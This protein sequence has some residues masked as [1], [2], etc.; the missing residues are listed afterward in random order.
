MD[1]KVYIE[2]VLREVCGVTE[3]TTCEEIIIKLAQAANLPGFYTLV[4]VYRGREDT[5]SADERLI[6][7]FR[8]IRENPTT[9]QFVLRRLEAPS[10]HPSRVSAQPKS[11]PSSAD[12]RSHVRQL[13][14]TAHFAPTNEAVGELRGPCSQTSAGLAGRSPQSLNNSVRLVGGR[15]DGSVETQQTSKDSSFNDHPPT[16]FESDEYEQLEDQLAYQEQ[17]VEFN[18]IRLLQLDKEIAELERA[19]RALAASD[20]FAMGPAAELAQLAATPWPQ[21]LE[22]NRTRQMDLVKE[23]ERYQIPLERIGVQLERAQEELTQLENKVAHELEHLLTTLD[24]ANAQR[25]QLLRSLS[26][27]PVRARL[28]VATKTDGIPV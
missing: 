25:R 7:F 22:A 2:G 15:S 9:V 19:N 12:H 4:A 1:L 5:L 23:R 21:L 17:E 28:P 3:S 13:S 27:T 24:S 10:P 6:E 14:S 20:A 18:R 8:K 11:H 26:P 16:R